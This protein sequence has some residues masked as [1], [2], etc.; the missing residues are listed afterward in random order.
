MKNQ[1]TLFK[2]LVKMLPLE[3]QIIEIDEKIIE[4][5]NEEPMKHLTNHTFRVIKELK[6]MNQIALNSLNNHYQISSY[7]NNDY[8]N[9]IFFN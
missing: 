7:K 5:R 4:V 8:D 9:L 3:K 2:N 1:F 6:Y